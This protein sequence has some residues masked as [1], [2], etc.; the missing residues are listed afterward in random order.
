MIPADDKEVAVGGLRKVWPVIGLAGTVA[1]P[2]IEA[3]GGE[4]TTEWQCSGVVEGI[5]AWDVDV[6]DATGEAVAVG[7]GGV[8]VSGGEVVEGEA[9]LWVVDET[10]A[11]RRIDV[12]YAAL[13]V[14]VS[15]ATGQAVVMH[16]GEG[17]PRSVSVV[18]LGT[19]DSAS[20][21]VPG[22][23]TSPVIDEA[24]GRAWFVVGPHGVGIL[25]IAT[26]DLEIVDLGAA[27]QDLALDPVA[28]R[29]FVPHGGEDFV[30][31]VDADTYALTAVP[32]G[33]ATGTVAVDPVTHRAFLTSNS[34]DEV[35]TVIEPD[36]S[37]STV[38]DVGGG[39][40]IAVDDTRE[41]VYVASRPLRALSETDL[42]V[43]TIETPFSGVEVFVDRGSGE[44]FI[45]QIDGSR[46]SVTDP[47][48]GTAEVVEMVD[49]VGATLDEARDRFWVVT[50]N[51][52][53]G[54]GTLPPALLLVERAAPG[55]TACEQWL[56]SAGGPPGGTGDDGGPPPA[57][58]QD[59]PPDF[60]G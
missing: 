14:E 54:P 35:V 22:W 41:R 5:D 11:A 13:E 24:T 29:V 1:F 19:G 23:P 42:S 38:L 60:T 46:V 57:P 12:G 30:S 36:L 58:P 50:R 10:L 49:F 18:D 4:P 43:S 47:A 21:G 34:D 52:G 8:L 51:T 20:V 9:W 55:D 59:D 28:R 31:V 15:Q 25:D 27:S 39:R 16:G 6:V 17:F 45:P 40:G 56:A 44:V 2:A 48:A 37:V 3:G 53:D 26:L 7:S 32:V 33:R